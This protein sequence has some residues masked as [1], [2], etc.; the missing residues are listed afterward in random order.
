MLKD[1]IKA[2]SVYH[3][4]KDSSYFEKKYWHKPKE[5]VYVTE[6]LAKKKENMMMVETLCFVY[7]T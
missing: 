7:N 6:Q 5:A 1:G 2:S 4:I 3:Q